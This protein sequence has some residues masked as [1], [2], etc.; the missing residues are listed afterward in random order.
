MF[1]DALDHYG[2]PRGHKWGY[3]WENQSKEKQNKTLNNINVHQTKQ[4]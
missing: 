3:R 4:K 1:R 2:D